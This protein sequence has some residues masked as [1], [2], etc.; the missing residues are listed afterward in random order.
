MSPYT[1]LLNSL[2]ELYDLGEFLPLACIRECS[3]SGDK[4]NDCREWCETLAFR[5]DREL[6]IEFLKDSGD[7]PHGEIAE[8]DNAK[9]AMNVLWLSANNASD[10]LSEL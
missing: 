2:P 4:E 7:Y 9:I 8:W 3:G 1:R 10:Y 6:A 5:P